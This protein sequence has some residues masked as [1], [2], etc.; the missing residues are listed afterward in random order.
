M[1]EPTPGLAAEHAHH[2][3]SVR[4][5]WIVFFSLA[6]L[7]A[8]ELQIPAM[9]EGND[10][11]R[12]SGAL[13]GALMVTAL[14]KAGLVAAFYMHLRY[15]SRTYSYMML[16]AIVVIMFF[17]WLLTWGAVGPLFDLFSG[18]LRAAPPFLV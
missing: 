16:V 6:I 2:G 10:P 3:P 18:G 8:I 5:Y 14:F 4:A 7:T 11:A 17:L 9:M 15:D 1:T 13:V 12:P